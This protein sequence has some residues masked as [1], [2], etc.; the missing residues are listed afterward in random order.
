LSAKYVLTA[1]AEADVRALIR[2]TR[3]KWGET[4]TRKYVATL[5]RGMAR[6][7]AGEGHFKDTSALYPMLRMVR[8]EHHYLFCL[9]RDDE[10]ALFVAILHE[11]MDFMVRISERLS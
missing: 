11:Q 10:P 5:E 9:P 7:A 8:C 4:Q 2:Y 3:A 6:L 1:A